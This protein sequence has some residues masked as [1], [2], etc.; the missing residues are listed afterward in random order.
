M[1]PPPGDGTDPYIPRP[2]KVPNTADIV[3]RA[4]DMVRREDRSNQSTN[5]TGKV[6]G[7]E[8]LPKGVV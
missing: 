4:V 1:I 2:S 3:A 5:P 7:T 8:I 6:E